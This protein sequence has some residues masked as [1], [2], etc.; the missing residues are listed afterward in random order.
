MRL[1]AQASNV[2]AVDKVDRPRRDINP[3]ALQLLV[4]KCVLLLGV[5]SGM[6]S[7]GWVGWEAVTVDG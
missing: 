5:S 3:S 7:R 6:G 4:C 2:A 1:S